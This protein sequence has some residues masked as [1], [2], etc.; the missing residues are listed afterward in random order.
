M[1]EKMNAA[2]ICNRIIT[3]AERSMPLVEAASLMRER[4]VGSLIV[5]DD[6]GAGRIAVGILTDRD[7]VTAVVAQGL[8]PAVLAV[9]DV[10][11]PNL[12]TALEEDSIKDLLSTMRQKGLRRLPIVTPQGLLVGLVTL[13]DLLPLMA[14]QL[15]DMAATIEAQYLH[16]R[17]DRP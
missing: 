3:V 9:E 13:D 1:R 14:D 6:T 16:E 12:V 7:I 4:H 10:M 2:D 15:R 11:T 5:V 8:D 17:R